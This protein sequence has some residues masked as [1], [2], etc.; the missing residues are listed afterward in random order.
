[1]ATVKLLRA[2]CLVAGAC[3]FGCTPTRQA[4]TP[5]PAEAPAPRKA[6]PQK[7]AEVQGLPPPS[8]AAAQPTPKVAKKRARKP[9]PPPPPPKVAEPPPPPPPPAPNPEEE[10]QR[11]RDAYLAAL[12]R[13]KFAFNPASPVEVGQRAAVALAV[14]T[15]AETAMLA[16]DLRKSL[17]DP[18]WTP[19]MRAKL[20]GA[21]FTIAPAEGKDSD[22]AKD[23][24]MTGRTEWGWS[25]VPRAPGSKTLIA[26]LTIG[27]PPALGGPRELPALQRPVEVEATLAWR[28]ERA[29][30]EYWQW[31]VGAIVAAL[32]LA[33]W[34]ARR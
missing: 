11:K 23:L 12:G 19:R 5:A 31:I 15:P 8:A 21:D 10:R 6:E 18:A 25:V 7:P 1:M 22:G 2:A 17:A 32:A 24:S 27:L 9:K 20:A 13:S 33:W 34:A 29:W 28:A 4:T 3:L 30:A 14:V 16:E 26:T